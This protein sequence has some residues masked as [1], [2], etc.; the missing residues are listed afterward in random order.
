[1][2]PLAAIERIVRKAGIDRISS[3]AI[4]EINKVTEELGV[5]LAREAAVLAEHAGRKTIQKE[6]IKIVAQ[7]D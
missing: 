4:K 3:K 7:K 6:D 2:L 1:M 5:D